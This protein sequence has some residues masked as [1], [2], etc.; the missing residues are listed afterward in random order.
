M[1]RSRSPISS[2]PK[3][4]SANLPEGVDPSLQSWT[5]TVDAILRGEARHVRFARLSATCEL[6]KEAG[7]LPADLVMSAAK[8][9]RARREH[10]EVALDIWH[11][12]PILLNDPLAIFPSLRDDGSIVVAL[13]VCD[14]DGNPIIVPIIADQNPKRNVVLSVYGKSSREKISGFDWIAAQIDAAEKRG[15]YVY[16][17]KDF[18]DSVPKPESAVAISS[19]PDPISV[20]GPAKPTR[21][22]LTIAQKVKDSLKSRSD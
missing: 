13:V 22:I 6:L 15:E 10:P 16:R 2:S 18:A 1:P 9:A 20:D 5:R 4:S 11:K 17:R 12:L 21:K 8:I 3:K 19:S 7:L 14:R